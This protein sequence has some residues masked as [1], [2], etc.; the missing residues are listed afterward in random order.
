M[1]DR[2]APFISITIA[3][4]Y[5]RR[6]SSAYALNDFVSTIM[7]G[8]SEKLHLTEGRQIQFTAIGLPDAEAS[9][10]NYGTQESALGGRGIIATALLTLVIATASNIKMDFDSVVLNM[11]ALLLSFNDLD[12]REDGIAVIELGDLYFLTARFGEQPRVH[13]IIALYNYGYH[14]RLVCSVTMDGC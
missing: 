13:Y 2:A 8:V 14:L 7:L 10:Y 1:P 9:N 6:I 11:M 12:C 5:K 4:L 3:P